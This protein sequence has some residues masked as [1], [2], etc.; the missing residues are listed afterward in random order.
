MPNND[1]RHTR[2]SYIRFKGGVGYGIMY[3]TRERHTMN[4]YDNDKIVAL[5]LLAAVAVTYFALGY[6]VL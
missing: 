4:D 1:K 6:F 5:S 2:I 3:V